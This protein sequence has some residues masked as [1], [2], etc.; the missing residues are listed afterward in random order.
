[1]RGKDSVFGHVRIFVNVFVCVCDQTVAGTYRGHYLRDGGVEGGR[2]GPVAAF[3]RAADLLLLQLQLLML[4][5]VLVL[6]LVMVMY[7]VVV[8]IVMVAAVGE[9]HGRVTVVQAGRAARVGGDD[10]DDVVWRQVVV[11]F[12]GVG[13]GRAS[14]G[15]CATRSDGRVRGHLGRFEP[16]LERVIGRGGHAGGG[17]G[18]GGGVRR[19]AGRRRRRRRR[20]SRHGRGRRSSRRRGRRRLARRRH[21]HG[22]ACGPG[23]R[24]RG[25]RLECRPPDDVEYASVA[26]DDGQA[27][28]DE[29]A[30]E[31]DLLGR[32][33]H[34]VRQY[35]ARAHGCV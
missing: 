21:G 20:R 11:L 2:R 1:M 23:D 22:G 24:G 6:V 35:R 10:D 17:C 27:G 31:Q 19:T 33:A 8:V 13:R 12:L 3:G 26:H 16:A 5:L 25:P 14:A 28:H 32:P 30:H 4:L 18:C 9:R 29:R 7:V 15:G 34:L